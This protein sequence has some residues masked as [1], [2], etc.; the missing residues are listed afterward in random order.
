MLLKVTLE[1][2]LVKDLGLDSLDHVEVIVQLEDTFGYE[3]PDSDYEK[4]MTPQA[5]V[6]Y[7]QKRFTEI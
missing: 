2:H 7:I 1:S 3:I 4:L 6:K 5:M